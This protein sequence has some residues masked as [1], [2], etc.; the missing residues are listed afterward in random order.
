MVLE[1]LHDLKL[2][3]QLAPTREVLS[4]AFSAGSTAIAAGSSSL[5]KAFDGV[6]S[7]ISSRLEAERAKRAVAGPSST[8]SGTEATETP[9]SAS[10]S[11][12]PWGGRT[13]GEAAKTEIV[14]DPTARNDITN[15][16]TPTPTTQPSAAS[17]QIPDIRATL[18][19]IGSGIG[20]FFGSRVASLRTPPQEVSKDAKPPSG[21]RPMSLT[22]TAKR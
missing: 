6:R 13:S 2:D 18:G 7:D 1:G 5:F 9:R 16:T 3:Q 8:A 4:S 15:Y 22:P 17:A 21:L 20:S 19:G 10:S 11:W 12:R 14:D